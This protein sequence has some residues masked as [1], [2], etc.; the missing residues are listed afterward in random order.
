LKETG[1]LKVRRCSCEALLAV[2]KIEKPKAPK[3]CALKGRKHHSQANKSMLHAMLNSF[4]YFVKFFHFVRANR[5]L[6][7]YSLCF[8]F[9]RLMY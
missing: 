2:S 3:G 1:S 9:F 5:F 7:S 6:N 4:P 8:M